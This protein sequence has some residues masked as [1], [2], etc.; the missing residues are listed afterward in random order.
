LRS[1]RPDMW[2]A[3]GGSRC[4][5]STRDVAP[6]PDQRKGRQGNHD[7]TADR[8]IISFLSTAA[9]S[10]LTWPPASL[11]GCSDPRRAPR[12]LRPASWSRAQGARSL[13]PTS[14]PCLGAGE[15]GVDALDDDGAWRSVCTHVGSPARAAGPVGGPGGRPSGSRRL[16]VGSQR[17]RSTRLRMNRRPPS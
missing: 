14:S 1:S 7:N 15:A 16:D 5:H 17:C 11:S 6:D 12:V 3:G 2:D 8:P 13:C 9:D 4:R 10:T